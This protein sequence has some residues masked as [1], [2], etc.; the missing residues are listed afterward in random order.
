MGAH[1]AG[2]PSDDG[3][4]I[5]GDSA[6]ATWNARD[7]AASDWLEDG[8]DDGHQ[9][10]VRAPSGKGWIVPSLMLAIIAGW[11]ALFGWA[12]RAA[13]LDGASL[14]QWTGWIGQW[15]VPVALVLIAWLILLR[16]S[17]RETGRFLDAARALNGEAAQLETRLAAT[18]RELAQAREFLAAQSRDLEAMGRIATSRLGEHADRLQALI[19]DNSAQVETIHTVSIAAVENMDQLREALPVAGAAARDLTSQIGQAGHE[20]E[21]RLERLND[22]FERL[23]QANGDGERQVAEFD[24]QVIAAL[25]RLR[26]EGERIDHIADTR[27]TALRDD[28]TQLGTD[29]RELEDSAA[30]RWAGTA[31]GLVERVRE[32]VAEVERIDRTA[33]EAAEARLAELRREAEEVDV[34]IAKRHKIFDD[35]MAKRRQNADNEILATDARHRDLLAERDAE[36]ARLQ[37]DHS[38]RIEEATGSSEA[39]ASR[40][41]ALEARLSDSAE[42]SRALADDLGESADMLDQR[43]ASSRE[44]LDA[45]GAALTE[46]TDASLRVLELIRE[47]ARHSEETLPNSL[48]LAESR[49]GEYRAEIAALGELLAAANETGA[50][51]TG[52]ARNAR[53]ESESGIAALDAF[54]A[55]SV[56]HGAGAEAALAAYR[57]QL[58]AIDARSRQV[59]EETGDRA[60]EALE[61][62][63]SAIADLAADIR[64]NGTE[65]LRE[66][67]AELGVLASGTIDEAIR[68][69]TA[70]AIGALEE[71]ATSAARNSRAITRD[72]LEQL[73]KVNELTGNLERRVAEARERAEDQQD[74]DF[75][76]RIALIT[77]SLNSCSIDIAKVLSNEVP[78][79]AWASYLKG[80]RGIFT[81]R[82]VRLIDRD[83][84]RAINTIYENEPDFRDHVN[85]YIH[86]FEAM[87]R[88]LLSTR[89]GNALAVTML[90]S[91]AGKLYVALA[92]AI[93]RLRD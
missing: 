12:N 33:L 63:R 79:T 48:G 44:S 27:M 77:E 28:A 3:S 31:D 11:T 2:A 59:S 1:T 7:E 34:A 91:D 80:D 58:E 51:V 56:E 41:A 82:A 38:A 65:P 5:D 46:V 17:R 49:L 83:D 4:D 16:T 76:R 60:A 19:A 6:Q 85:R 42:Q 73:G 50:Q 64:E 29:L 69:N 62:L 21:S 47:G 68:A 8:L 87:L 26:A 90:G 55:R 37:S 78:D 70:E 81:R 52:H 25:E 35:H 30:E 57:D 61:A 67:A 24:T 13:M 75:S 20:A 39:L 45:T 18:N 89:D 14:Q 88:T 53:E 54:H 84:S 72:L 10:P 93:E 15:A 9:E 40:I 86:D 23:A 92:Q 71:Q 66:L 43:L 36:L 22:G 32:A 74:D